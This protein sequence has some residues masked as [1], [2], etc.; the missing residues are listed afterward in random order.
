MEYSSWILY[1]GHI[2][3]LRNITYQIMV[4]DYNEKSFQVLSPDAEYQIITMP[5][6]NVG[7]Q[8]LYEGEITNITEVNPDNLYPYN[9]YHKSIPFDAYVAPHELSKIDY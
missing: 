9:V 7:D 8:V 6:F 1:N 4:Y 3:R 2:C 5:E